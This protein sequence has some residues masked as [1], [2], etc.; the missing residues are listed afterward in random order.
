M[1][2]RRAEAKPMPMPYRLDTR[3]PVALGISSGWIG[4]LNRFIFSSPSYYDCY[5]STRGQGRGRCLSAST[6]ILIPLYSGL[7]IIF[8]SGNLISRSPPSAALRLAATGGRGVT[9]RTGRQPTTA[10]GE[11]ALSF[12]GIAATPGGCVAGAPKTPMGVR[13][14]SGKKIINTQTLNGCMT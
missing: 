8:Y 4:K 7:F 2:A 5:Y 3:A 13:A 6:N 14:R 11:G 12:A 9:P 1:L 10:A